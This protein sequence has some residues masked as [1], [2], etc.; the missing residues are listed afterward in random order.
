M[1][2]LGGRI[3]KQ[4]LMKCI[5]STKQF[6]LSNLTILILSLI[7]LGGLYFVLYSDKFNDTLIKQ[8]LPV[9]TKPISFNLDITNPDDELLVFDKSQV[10][11]GKTGPRTNVII[12]LSEQNIGLQANGNGEFSKVIV[13]SKGLNEITIAAFDSEGNSKTVSRTIYYS[14]E[15]L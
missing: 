8:Y 11:S 14:E 1:M 7:F 6:I 3:M 5:L 4:K 2:I 9:T 10:I 13:L 15:K 12:S